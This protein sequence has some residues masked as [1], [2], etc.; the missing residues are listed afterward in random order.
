MRRSITRYPVGTSL[1]EETFSTLSRELDRLFNRLMG[2]STTLPETAES[3]WTPAVDLI[4]TENEYLVYVELP[5]MNREDFRLTFS[6]N[7]LTISG[8]RK[9]ERKE[10]WTYHL[11]ELPYGRFHRT[12]DFPTEVDPDK[13]KAVYHNGVLEIRVPKAEGARV[14]EIPIEEK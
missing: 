4:E 13:V 7:S 9:F 12:V 11:L 6:G 3:V 2:W 10:N 1:F 14:K 8:E 5:G